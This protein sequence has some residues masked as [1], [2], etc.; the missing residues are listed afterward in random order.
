MS[1]DQPFRIR[2]YP[3]ETG[4]LEIQFLEEFFGEFDR[5]KSAMEIRERLE[6][7][8]HGIFMVEA[9]LP[10]E[11]TRFAPVSYRVAHEIRN[12]E[13]DP[14]LA[15][16]VERLREAVRFSG[17]RV[18][19]AWLGGTR[20]D[21]RGQGHFRALD[22]FQE[23]WAID[24]GFREI[25][26]KTKNRYYEMRSTLTHLHFDVVKYE[27]HPIHNGDSKVY[28]SKRLG[29]AMRRPRR[30]SLARYLEV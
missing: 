4:A 1:L 11:P 30:A 10:E 29:G 13:T 20:S 6:G 3:L 14:E 19:Y 24:K 25:V 2:Q 21:W 22:E 23:E 8:E 18:L 28:L 17:Q 26:V 27:P 7:R 15:D 12:E 5:K 16:L 9:S